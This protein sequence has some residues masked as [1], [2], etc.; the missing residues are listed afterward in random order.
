L[1]GRVISYGKSTS[2]ANPLIPVLF[3]VNNKAGMLPGRFV[4][5]FII[6]RTNQQ[7]IVVPNEAI[8]EEMGN[9][10]VYV[11]LTPE[12]FEKRMIEKGATD[13]IRVEITKGIAEGERAVSKGAIFVKLAQASGSLDAH[14]GH[15]H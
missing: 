1:G 6:T 3:Q 14:A 2:M 15:A 7:A 13:G 11:Q 10:F 8:V 5:L 4:E 12:L 9:Y